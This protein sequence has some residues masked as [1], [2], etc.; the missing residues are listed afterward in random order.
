M[1]HD[2]KSSAGHQSY[3]CWVGKYDNQK[4]QI[5]DQGPSGSM[6]KFGNRLKGHQIAGCPPVREKSGKFVF[7]SRSGKSQGI[8]YNGQGN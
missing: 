1:I 2:S 5:S 7:S 4:S 3:R 8:L 6:N